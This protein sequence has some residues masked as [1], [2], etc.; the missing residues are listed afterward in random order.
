ML[1]SIVALIAGLILLVTASPFK[2]SGHRNGWFKM[3]GVSQ[4]LLNELPEADWKSI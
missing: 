3:K 2:T 4:D 1:A